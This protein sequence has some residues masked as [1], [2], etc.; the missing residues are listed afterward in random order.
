MFASRAASREGT[1]LRVVR[2]PDEIE[3]LGP[4][5]RRLAGRAELPTASHAWSAAAARTLAGAGIHVLVSR[6]QGQVTAIAP[7]AHSPE[8]LEILGSRDLGEPADLLWRSPADI[9]PVAGHLAASGAVVSLRRA[10]A[11]SP[12]VD[13]L[14]RARTLRRILAVKPA[15]GAPS[16]DL[17]SWREGNPLS[18]RRRSDLRRARR[19]AEEHGEIAGEVHA[20]GPGEAEE[21]LERA[22]GVEAACWKARAGTALACDPL[23]R[24]F[25]E[26]LVRRTAAD[27]S[28]RMGF[29]TIGGETAAMQIAVVHAE[30][31]WLLKIGYDERY[32]RCS[33]G[34]LLMLEAV[35]HAAREGRRSFEL[36]GSPEP[37]T[38]TWTRR[39][40]PMVAARLYPGLRGIARLG[41]DV[42]HEA[43]T[44]LRRG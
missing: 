40:R 43:R 23:R 3:A 2:D 25:F 6:A 35:G 29:L 4:E 21:L 39:L 28:L 41:R 14:R 8:G 11:G 19:R 7:L 36:L 34:M 5:W 24:P 38:Q 17:A 12:S 1:A 16:V 22:I 32:G 26:E 20:P 42:S 9:D 10:P 31:L 13:A 15:A 37:W 44:H 27:G 33:P 18:S 30:S